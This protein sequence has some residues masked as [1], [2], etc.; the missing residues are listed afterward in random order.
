MITYIPPLQMIIRAIMILVFTAM[1][2]TNLFS[3]VI[4]GENNLCLG[5]TIIYQ[6]PA[7]TSYPA[8]GWQISPATASSINQYCSDE[9][10]IS[11]F[12]AGA[13]EISNINGGPGYS[14]TVYDPV[15]PFLTWDKE[16]RC[17]DFDYR[18]DNEGHVY[19]IDENQCTN[20]C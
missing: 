3:Q 8:T 10:A 14:V 11:W 13:Y 19:I 18:I 5:Q 7:G 1:N 20:A 15:S 16:A 6:V 17:T 4:S 2:Q 12:N 9:I